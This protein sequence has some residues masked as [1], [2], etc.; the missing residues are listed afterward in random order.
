MLVKY[1]KY[2]AMFPIMLALILLAQPAWSR[3][4]SR[5]RGGGDRDGSPRMQSAERAEKNNDGRAERNT[6]NQPTIPEP[7][8]W[9]GYE[10]RQDSDRSAGRE[11]NFSK[12]DMRVERNNTRVQENRDVH[13]E[14]FNDSTPAQT[15]QRTFENIRAKRD[16]TGNRISTRTPPAADRSTNQSFT[17][18]ITTPDAQMTAA[19]GHQFRHQDRNENIFAKTDRGPHSQWQADSRRENDNI[20]IVDSIRSQRTAESR[21]DRHFG[22]DRRSGDRDRRGD[23]S[24]FATRNDFVFFDRHHFRHHQIVSPDFFFFLD[25]S[26]GPWR[27]F[28]PVYPYYHRGYLFVNPCGYWPYDYDYMRYYWYGCSPYY[29]YGYNPVPYQYGSSDTY[30]YYTYNYYNSSTGQP[31]AGSYDN[32]PVDQTALT[33]AQQQAKPPATAT[34]ADNYFDEGVKAFGD[35]DYNTAAQK[36]A[37]ARHLA[38]EDK[39]LPF[40]YSQA[41]FAAG[42]YTQAAESLREAL[43]KVNPETEGVF[44]P[45]GLYSTDD[46]LIKQIDTL[47]ESANQNSQDANLQLLLGYHQLGTGELDKAAAPLHQA[48]ADQTNAPAANSLIKLLDKLQAAQTETPKN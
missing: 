31:T 24:I 32:Q 15:E 14:R 38:P 9:L 20:R 43:A 19:T 17:K 30:N 4:G 36:F 37:L 8:H 46:D 48:A 1:K 39:V 18:T 26:F 5:G 10:N 23:H 47:N 21:G 33:N 11:S 28:C 40:A 6:S 29:W 13:N 25:F 34:S 2:M 22:D 42:N 45:R 16:F 44:Y 35:G 3:E 27:S 7:R 12:P 41:L